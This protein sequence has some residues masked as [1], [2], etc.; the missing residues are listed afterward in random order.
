MWLHNIL[1]QIHKIILKREKIAIQQDN[2]SSYIFIYLS[3]LF[4]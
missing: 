4:I 2:P 1:Q 3:Y